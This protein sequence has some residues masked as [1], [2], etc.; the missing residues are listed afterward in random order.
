MVWGYPYPAE[1]RHTV[2]PAVED[3]EGEDVLDADGRRELDLWLLES[4]VP[5]CTR[6]RAERAYEQGQEDVSRALPLARVTTLLADRARM[7]A[8]LMEQLPGSTRWEASS[9]YDAE[10]EDITEAVIALHRR[11]QQR[12]NQPALSAHAKQRLRIRTVFMLALLYRECYGQLEPEAEEALA[13]VPVDRHLRSTSPRSFRTPDG[14]FWTHTRHEGWE[15]HAPLTPASLGRAVHATEQLADAAAA[16]GHAQTAIRARRTADGMRAQLATAVDGQAPPSPQS[17]LPPPVL[18]RSDE[19]ARLVHTPDGLERYTTV[20]IQT[21]R[22]RVVAGRYREL[23]D[24]D[25]DTTGSEGEPG[26]PTLAAESSSS[27]ETEED[28]GTERPTAGTYARPRPFVRAAARIHPQ[29]RRWE[30][31]KRN[32]RIVQEQLDTEMASAAQ[33][34][35][36][37]EGGYIAMMNAIKALWEQ[38]CPHPD[39][40]L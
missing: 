21:P 2:H 26:P 10:G 20:V 35:V 23:R 15:R 4:Q 14:A 30:V 19:R 39:P 22:D 13:Q 9:C 25:A 18:Q 16:R 6:E 37:S 33:G 1:E 32:L 29:D 27:S 7:V 3:E 24:Q 40:E 17:P 36:M 28:D 11:T 5:G 31:A 38:M 8:F 34:V 12:L